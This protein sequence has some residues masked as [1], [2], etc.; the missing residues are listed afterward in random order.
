MVKNFNARLSI[1]QGRWVT[2]SPRC[3]NAPEAVQDEYTPPNPNYAMG[4]HGYIFVYSI[5]SK[6]SFDMIQIVYDKI[7]DF[8]GM[9]DIPCIIVGTKCDLN[10]GYVPFG[11]SLSIEFLTAA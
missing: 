5:A 6:N 10:S 4:I 11:L 7:V 2:L 3:H 9:T 1:R 8:S